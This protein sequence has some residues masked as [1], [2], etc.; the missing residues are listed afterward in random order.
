[1]SSRVGTKAFPILTALRRLVA[2][3]PEV[4]R[5]LRLKTTGAAALYALLGA[6]LARGLGALVT[7]QAWYGAFVV[8]L[9][10]AFG[11][12]LN[13][14]CDVM[15]DRI[16]NPE[17][18]LAAGALSMRTAEIVLAVLAA[19]ALIV[20]Y[21]LGLWA[22]IFTVITIALG[23]AY[24]FWLK[25][26]ILI[27]NAVIALLD[28][29]IVIFGALTLSG[30]SPAIVLLGGIMALCALAEEILF[31]ADDVEG[32]RRAGLK[33][34]ATHWGIDASVRAYL[35]AVLAFLLAAPLPWLIGVAP[36]RYLIAV[37]ACSMLPVTI[38]G[39]FVSRHRT[40]EA[41]RRGEMWMK[42]VWLLSIVPVL[43]LR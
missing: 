33:T 2:K 14:R 24:S 15:V 6:Y 3:S 25:N 9:V 21:L 13:D 37:F 7:R 18:P 4:L 38:I 36:S 1:M 42:V 22:V 32:D 8:G 20:A 40:P 16:N 39:L 10:V 35:A 43:M 29:S 5:I 41:I 28:G 23:C 27:G 17:R 30:L 26:T 19:A 11:F 31:T 34:I 12:V